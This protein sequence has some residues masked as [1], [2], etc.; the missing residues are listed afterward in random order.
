MEHT[1]QHPLIT[2]LAALMTATPVWGADPSPA[3]GSP[4]TVAVRH[5]IADLAETFG[6]R[7]PGGQ[8]FLGRLA[9]SEQRVPLPQED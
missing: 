5:A 1:M 6:D 8:A 9:G 4:E 2:G 3:T 7:Y